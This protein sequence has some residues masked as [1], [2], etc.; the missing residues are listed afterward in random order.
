MISIVLPTFNGE[1]FIEKA[2]T[3]VLG[4]TYTDFELI[5][6]ND[7]STDSTLAII[8]RYAERDDRIQ[9]INNTSNQKLPRSLNTGFAQARGDFFTW[10]SDD[11]FYH[12]DALEKMM[13]YLSKNKDKDIVYAPY[14]YIDE[15]DKRIGYSEQIDGDVERLYLGNAIGACFLYKREVHEKLK[16]YDAEQFLVEDYDFWLRAMRYFNYGFISECLYE[17]RLH[18]SSLTSQRSAL[19][20]ARRIYLQKRELQMDNPPLAMKGQIMI[21]LIKFYY[22]T[23]DLENMRKYIYELKALSVEDYKRMSIAYKIANRLGIR[24]AKLLGEKKSLITNSFGICR[25]I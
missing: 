18:A 17:Y 16:G 2:I 25:K 12:K 3:E 6:V 23:D 19:I 4:Q 11:N 8:S 5:V 10:T 20:K 24:L 14:N 13:D 9:I 7:C 1:K 22:D 21:N 15:N